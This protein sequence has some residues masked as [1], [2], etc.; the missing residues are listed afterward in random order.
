M[1]PVM[2]AHV[3]VCVRVL[4]L[5]S[6]YQQSLFPHPSDDCKLTQ[7][8]QKAHIQIYDNKMIAQR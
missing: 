5:P 1:D 4:L 8:N 7:S 2:C 6:P 3:C